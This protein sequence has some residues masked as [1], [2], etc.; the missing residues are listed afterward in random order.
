MA[1]PSVLE[2]GVAS[3]YGQPW[4]EPFLQAP[5]STLLADGSAVEVYPGINV[6]GTER[7]AAR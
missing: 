6:P 3:R 1:P 2:A 4:V 7:S 5:V